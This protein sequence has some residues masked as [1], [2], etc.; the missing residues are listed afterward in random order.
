MFTSI[1]RKIIGRIRR[2]SFVQHLT[3]GFEDLNRKA[4]IYYKTDPYWAPWI[5][6]DYSHTNNWEIVQ[7]QRILNKLGFSVDVI[8]RNCERFVPRKDYSLFMGLGAGN[9]GKHFSRIAEALPG[10]VKIMLAMGP[11]PDLSNELVVNQYARFAQRTGIDAPPMR[12]VEHVIGDEFTRIMNHTDYVFAFGEAHC[13]SAQTYLPFGKPVLPLYPAISPQVGFE[14]DWLK[15]R[16][17]NNFLCFAGNGFICKGV[18]LLVE[19]FSKMPHMNLTI[20]GPK[21]ESSFF[22]AYKK[23]I[24]DSSNISFAGFVSVDTPQYRELCAQ[25]AYVI[26]HPSKEA[27][28]TSV[29]TCMRA[30]LVP[31]LNYETGIDIRDYGYL[32]EGTDD[33]LS[34]I[35]DAVTRA[36]NLD[37][38]QYVTRSLQTFAD[39]QK[40]SQESFTTSMT[41]N[42]VQV[43]Q[44]NFHR[45]SR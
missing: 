12:T 39:S 44:D 38:D 22:R 34:A 33:P 19:A 14:I 40:Y 10:A 8:D 30:G 37:R 41:K 20:C 25:N 7:L 15:S 24:E 43:I 31:V 16:K 9:S 26:F 36:S 42:L 45:F 29:A 17:L 2:R 18:D 28:A 21:T 3:G 13:F 27:C 32:I 1:A 6:D 4:L 23:I 5:V 11:A 35:R